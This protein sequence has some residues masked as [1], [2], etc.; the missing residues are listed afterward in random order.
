MREPDATFRTIACFH[1]IVFL[2]DTSRIHAFATLY[3]EEKNKEGRDIYT[4]K[5]KHVCRR[6]L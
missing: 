1:F 6:F 3:T 2:S 4:K 5:S